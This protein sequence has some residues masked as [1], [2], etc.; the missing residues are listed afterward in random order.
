LD[1]KTI[2][3]GGPHVTFFWTERR[4]QMKITCAVKILKDCSE[5]LAGLDLERGRKTFNI[6][7]VFTAT[8]IAFPA[9]TFVQWYEMLQAGGVAFMHYTHSTFKNLVDLYLMA[10]ILR[11]D[12]AMTWIEE[13]AN[14]KYHLIS[15]TWEEHYKF[16]KAHD[17]DADNSSFPAIARPGPVQEQAA[18]LVDIQQ[19]W[20]TIRL[21]NRARL[22]RPA[23]LA[24]LVS[25]ACP[26]ELRARM[27]IAGQLVPDFVRAVA[28]YDIRQ[29]AQA[30]RDAEVRR[31]A[32]GGGQD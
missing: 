13:S 8:P 7:G 1:Y 14:T 28:L 16:A 25:V 24:Q 18:V 30:R 23:Q 11:S 26:W 4:G 20:M 19:A 5:L 31:D 3:L 2:C 10:N 6:Q 9:S 12:L 17:N 21:D 15:A 27:Q 22:F 32:E 29:G